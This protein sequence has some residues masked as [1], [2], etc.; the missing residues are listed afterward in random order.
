MILGSIII[1]SGAFYAG[2]CIQQN[3]SDYATMSVGNSPDPNRRLGSLIAVMT[4]FKLM[5]G[6]LIWVYMLPIL[7]IVGMVT[8]H[9]YM[10]YGKTPDIL[11]TIYNIVERF[12]IKLLSFLMALVTYNLRV[13]KLSAAV[14]YTHWEGVQSKYPRIKK[15]TRCIFEPLAL[16]L[17]YNSCSCFGPMYCG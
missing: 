17:V 8:L 1:G 2:Y 13:K 15:R 12:Q 7:C 5:F 3:L 9:S 11:M 10:S 4:V 14:D 16:D 6:G